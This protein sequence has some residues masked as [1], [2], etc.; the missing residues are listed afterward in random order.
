MS[1]PSS[2]RATSPRHSNFRWSRSFRRSC[3]CSRWTRSGRNC[4]NDP[5]PSSTDCAWPSCRSL[6]RSDSRDP[7]GCP[8]HWSSHPGRWSNRS[9]P[10]RRSRWRCSRW[11]RGCATLR[12]RRRSRCAP[13]CRSGLRCSSPAC[14]SRSC[15]WAT[16]CCSS[17]SATTSRCGSMTSRSCCRPAN[18]PTSHS[19]HPICGLPY[20]IT[21]TAEV[22]AGVVRSTFER[23][24][25]QTN[26][27][28]CDATPR[29]G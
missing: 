15:R 18:G 3:C 29:F 11:N 23:R 16:S 25:M 1:D 24:P 2:C 7:C 4:S 27:G 26:G 21:P 13:R 20:P 8:N 17:P 22:V 6:H 14:S 9:S 28:R 10:R 12:C 5:S 19:C